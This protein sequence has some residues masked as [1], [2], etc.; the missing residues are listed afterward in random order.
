MSVG[1]IRRWGCIV[2]AGL[3]VMVMAAPVRGAGDATWPR[4]EL[5]RP[6][7]VV[8]TTIEEE[9]I[10]GRLIAYDGDA[11][12][13]RMDDDRVRRVA[14]ADLPT[15]RAYAMLSKLLEGRDGEIWLGLGRMMLAR[16]DG[17]R[18]ADRALTRAVYLDEALRPRAQRIRRGEEGESTPATAPGTPGA[19]PPG[20]P[21]VPGGDGG[22]EVVGPIQANFW[23]P[24]TDAQQAAA[25]DEL[26]AFAVEGMRAANVDLRLI[27][28]RY[29]L[30]YS[31]LDATEARKWAGLLDKMYDRLCELFGIQEGVNVWRGKCLIFVFAQEADYHRFELT[32]HGAPSIGTAGKCWSFG[33]GAVHVSFYRQADR[34]RFAHV[35]VHESVHGF[36]HRYRSPAR[37]ASVW[38][39]GLAE[40]IAMELVPRDR[41]G[42]Y[43]QEMAA[44]E[45]KRRG[46]LGMMF[47]AAHI[48]AWHYG[49][50]SSLTQMLIRENKDGYVAFI[51]GIKDGTP[52]RQS[53]KENYGVGLDRLVAYFGRTIGVR[54]LEP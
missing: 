16:A 41:T 2:A 28:T 14:W 36:L 11:L 42:G 18:F 1:M 52:W 9:S 47:D 50:A 25:I 21:G 51:N 33:S 17:E 48:E 27:E 13:L 19:T 8:V 38:N 20:T 26:N 32:A 43:W 44:A 30:F 54:G 31:D 6:A 4:V 15:R 12:E 45:L 53:L 39:E 22:P 23:G 24:Q 34:D 46:D 40:V 49:I 7:N 29:F 3:T 35:L 37:I 10:S 5:D